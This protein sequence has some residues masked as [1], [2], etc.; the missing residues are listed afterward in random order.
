MNDRRPPSLLSPDPLVLKSRRIKVYK[1]RDKE[2]Y[3]AARFLQ[4]T[5]PDELEHQDVWGGWEGVDVEAPGQ[6]SFASASCFEA[7]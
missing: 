6:L 4:R 3:Q 7:L 1:P 2:G 5:G